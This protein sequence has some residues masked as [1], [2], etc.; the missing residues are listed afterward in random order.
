MGEEH[1]MAIYIGKEQLEQSLNLFKRENEVK[2]L[3]GEIKVGELLDQ[4]LPDDTYLIA[5][6]EIGDYQ[7]DF[8]VIS[9][10]YGFRII[11]VKNH[12]LSGINNVQSNGN[13]INKHRSQNY[14]N[15]VR[16]H[17]DDLKSYLLS[18]HPYLGDTHRMIGYCVVNIGFTKGEFETRFKVQIDS[19]D[20][21][22][23]LDFF[24]YHLFV[25]QLNGH[26]D[27]TIGQA[28]KFP[29]HRVQSLTSPRIKEIASNL[30]IG[31]VTKSSYEDLGN[32][33][34]T[35]EGSSTVKSEEVEKKKSVLGKWIVPIVVVIMLPVFIF[36]FYSNTNDSGVNLD[37]IEE[38]IGET[39]RLEAEVI[40]FYYDTSSHT[41]FLTLRSETGTIKAVIF[42]NVK[43][44]YINEGETYT[45]TGLVQ[46][47][48]SDIELKVEN[49]E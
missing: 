27:I 20:E 49:V 12:S 38:H 28:T 35:I 18:N 19:W 24:K 17:V 37:R 43:V 45:F 33:V 42:E 31:E 44:P 15:Q 8:L 46:T 22:H 1:T 36:Y 9:P 25:D 26:I 14:I 47:Y 48:N 13:F 2:G 16:A 3:E 30:K 7:P 11:E 21:T 41:K 29:N 39:I 10:R 40:K 23:T 34:S 5:Q 4:Y 6:P 32:L